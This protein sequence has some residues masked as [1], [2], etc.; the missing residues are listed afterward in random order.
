M[1][2]KLI[3]ISAAL[4][5]LLAFAIAAVVY[6]QQKSRAAAQQAQENLAAMVRPHSPVHGNPAARVTIVEFI[7]PACETCRAFYPLVKG[8][9]QASFGQVRLVLRY[10]PLHQGSDEVVKLLEAARQQNLFWPVLET[11]L[12]SQ[13]AWV[14]QH[15]AHPAL[16][17]EQL[18]NTGL[19]V[20]RAKAD[21]NSS[22]VTNN[23]NQDVADARTLNVTKTP[24]YFVNGK[25][26][27][28]FGWEPLQ[29]LVANELRE[30][31]GK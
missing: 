16:A 3:V 19:D 24:G 18:K 26:L 6:T 14:L 21:M 1:N 23:V 22:T 8:L 31:Q 11:L 9:V 4:L 28:N 20:A 10:A 7:D 13:S 29:T 12:E 27:V 17:W 5:A 25:P 15:K 2:K 30:T